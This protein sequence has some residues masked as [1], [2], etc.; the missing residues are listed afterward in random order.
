MLC[1][2]SVSNAQ[3]S[4]KKWGYFADVGFGYLPVSE[5]FNGTSSVA[6]GATYRGQFGLGLA[7]SSLTDEL[8]GITGL[9]LEFRLTPTRWLLL[10][11]QGGAILNATAADNGTF[12]ATALITYLPNE[13]E[14]YYWRTTAAV[15]FLRVLFVGVS[16]MGT[17][18]Q[19][20]RYENSAT[21]N[22]P[23]I[24]AEQSNVFIWQ[25]GLSLPALPKRK[26]NS[27]E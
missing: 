16:R 8:K 21:T 27:I 3:V 25:L 4:Q 11:V 7:Y 15:R 20:F 24:N 19:A 9:G 26:K 6:A 12:S 23:T 1:L 17:G 18:N 22:P 10:K 13:S 14:R 2:T 5:G